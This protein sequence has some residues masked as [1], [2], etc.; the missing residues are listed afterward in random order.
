MSHHTSLT[1]TLFLD[2]LLASWFT[3][4]TIQYVQMR[5]NILALVWL[6]MSFGMLASLFHVVLLLTL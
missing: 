3:H 1:I 4:L 5:R 2:I 6:A